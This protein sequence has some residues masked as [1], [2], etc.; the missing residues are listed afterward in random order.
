M[1]KFDNG[2]FVVANNMQI[3][4]GISNA[5]QQG[6]QQLLGIMQEELAETRR[7]NEILLGI[8]NKK[9]GIDPSDAFEATRIEAEEYTRR[10][11]NPAFLY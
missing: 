6:N 10:T 2:K 7:Q 5:V 3:T 8:L 11:G 4:E 1:G 9:F